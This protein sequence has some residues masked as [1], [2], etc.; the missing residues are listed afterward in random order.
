MATGRNGATCDSVILALERARGV[1]EQIDAEQTEVAGEFRTLRI[2]LDAVGGGKAECPRRALRA[3]AITSTDQEPN[4]G[5]R[6]KRPG[7]PITEKSRAAE[8]QN[9]SDGRCGCNILP[10]RNDR[11]KILTHSR[12]RPAR[13]GP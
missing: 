5:L 12:N 2:D 8:D 1:N 6:R 10:A 4:A 7:D 9:C 3:R 11:A 13:F